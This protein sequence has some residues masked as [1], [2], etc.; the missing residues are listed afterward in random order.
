[1]RTGGGGGGGGG[2]VGQKQN[3]DRKYGRFNFEAYHITCAC[4]SFHFLV[5]ALAASIIVV[6]RLYDRNQV[7]FST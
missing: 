1:M 6:S 5:Y 2:G 3:L 4:L 7:H